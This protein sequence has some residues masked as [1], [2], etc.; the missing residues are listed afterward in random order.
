M[1]AENGRID[2]VERIARMLAWVGTPPSPSTSTRQSG[3]VTACTSSW[4][5]S[6]MPC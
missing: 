6:D 3:Q 4:T 5:V 2:E 1:D